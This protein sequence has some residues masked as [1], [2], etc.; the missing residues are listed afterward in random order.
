M[1]CRSGAVAA[2]HGEQLLD[3]DKLSVMGNSTVAKA[4]LPDGS[5]VALKVLPP[6]LP[7]CVCCKTGG[8]GPRLGHE[9]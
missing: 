8:F 7:C 3:L 6:P 2:L 4:T 9:A 5:P 1:L